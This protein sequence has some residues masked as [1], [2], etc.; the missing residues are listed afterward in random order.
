MKQSFKAYSYQSILDISDLIG[1]I[2]F[3][4]LELHVFVK[5]YNKYYI[6]LAPR[7]RKRQ[8]PKTIGFKTVSR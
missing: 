4:T 8:P 6:L 3:F 5:Y 1:M 2:R 7:Q